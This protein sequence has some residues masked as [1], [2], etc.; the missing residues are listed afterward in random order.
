M[1]LSSEGKIYEQRN[2]L[3][4]EVSKLRAALRDIAYADPIPSPLAAFEYCR[5]VATQA[6]AE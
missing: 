1:T 2:A 6:L 5:N 3:Q 4:D